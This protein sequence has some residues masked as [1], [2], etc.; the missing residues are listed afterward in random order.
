M[1]RP[2]YNVDSGKIIG[3]FDYKYRTSF[4]ITF[5]QSTQ[6]KSVLLTRNGL[7]VSRYFNT[8]LKSYA[9]QMD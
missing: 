7:Y 3:Y 6:W 8:D 2:I 1:L 5:L 9:S 4:E